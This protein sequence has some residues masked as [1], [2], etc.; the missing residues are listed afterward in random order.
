MKEGDRILLRMF[1]YNH[2]Y[3]SKLSSAV[4]YFEN[5]QDEEAKTANM[6][7]WRYINFKGEIKKSFD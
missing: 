2:N 4:G 7:K 6:R 5:I 1:Q 3:N